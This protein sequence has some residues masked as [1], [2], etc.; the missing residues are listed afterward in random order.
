MSTLTLSQ[1]DLL[2][3]ANSAS[4]R[5]IGL[6]V[7]LHINLEC[8]PA[9]VIRDLMHRV[10]DRF[11]VVLLA[12]DGRSESSSLTVQGR[13]RLLILSR[14]FDRRDVEPKLVPCFEGTRDVESRIAVVAI[15]TS[16]FI[17]P[18]LVLV[19]FVFAQLAYSFVLAWR[20]HL[21]AFGDR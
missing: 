6:L 9:A 12:P 21:E 19:I 3:L 14:S 4:Q 17:V 7:E 20:D 1:L 2:S 8:C 18:D 13:N 16:A 11:D 5:E 15:D 10:D